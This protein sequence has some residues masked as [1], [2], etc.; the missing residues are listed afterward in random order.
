MYFS[1]IDHMNGLRSAA[2]Q[3]IMLLCS[4]SFGVSIKG[5][6]PVVLSALRR[7]SFMNAALACPCCSAKAC[8]EWKKPSTALALRAAMLNATIMTQGPGAT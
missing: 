3:R 6:A 8:S 2:L 7:N 4:H 1:T 5:V